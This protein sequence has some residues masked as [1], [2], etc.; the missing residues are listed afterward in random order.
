[1]NLS[2]GDAISV[3]AN[4]RRRFPNCEVAVHPF[5]ALWPVYEVNLAVTALAKHDLSTT[6]RFIL[7]LANLR[8]NQPSELAKTLGLSEDYIAGASAELLRSGYAVQRPD[9]G[10][11]LTD[12]GRRTLLNGGRSFVPQNHYLRVPYDPLT[13]GVVDLGARRL[14]TLY[15]ARQGGEFVIPADHHP[16]RLSNL[17]IDDVRAVARGNRYFREREISEITQIS[18]IKDAPKLKYRSDLTLVGM[19]E[20]RAE[21][22]FF[23]VYRGRQYLREQSEALRRLTDAGADLTP[24]EAKPEQAKAWVDAAAI[25]GHERERLSVLADLAE[26]VGN[27]DRDIAIEKELLKTSD[28]QRERA[29]SSARIKELEANNRDLANRL[30]Q[31]ERQLKEESQGKERLLKTEEHRA[32]LLRAIKDARSELT[33]VS[34]WITPRAFDARVRSGIVNA[35]KR[36]VTVRIAWGM[37]DSR[38]SEG[39]RNRENGNNALSRLRKIIPRGMERG[40]T[41]KYA[42]THQ[43]FIVC[44]DLFCAAGSLNWLSYRGE[45][46]SGYRT[47]VSLYSESQNIIDLYKTQAEGIFA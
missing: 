28:S 3:L 16:P 20:P 12:E 43:K 19:R 46:D 6:S 33:L 47:E 39:S 21:R 27:V 1:M 22:P 10:I 15:A 13:G 9:M 35:L 8:V 4:A 14:A 2:H 45:I 36:G 42:N 25:S 5:P 17:P 38:N 40:L 31:A 26:Q 11:E 24:Q 34:A 37:P 32:I 18:Q 30:A 29:A 41:V 7:R 44:D 23:V